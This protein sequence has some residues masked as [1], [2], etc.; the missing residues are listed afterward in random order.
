MVEERRS[1]GRRVPIGIAAVVLATGVLVGCGGSSSS[2]NA[3]KSTSNTVNVDAPKQTGKVDPNATLTVAYPADPATFDPRLPVNAYKKNVDFSIYDTLVVKDYHHPDKPLDI[4][5]SLATEWKV[6]DDGLTYSFTLRDGVKFSDGSAFDADD[7]V[8]TFRSIVDKSFKGF[9]EECNAASA[10]DNSNID[11]VAKTGP[12]AVDIKLKKPFGGFLEMLSSQSQFAILTA[13]EVEAGSKAINAKPIG[14]GY[15]TLKEY[16][17]N[18][19]VVLERND[20]HWRGPVAYKELIIR[21]MP[22]PVAR[23]NAIVAGE[24]D[25]ANDIAPAYITEWADNDAVRAVVRPRPRQYTCQMNYRGDGPTSKKEVR[26]AL[27][28]A[29]DRDAMNKAL[30]QGRGTP[31]SGW[32][33]AGNPAFDK[34]MPELAYDPAKA[35]QLLDAAGYGKG[36]KLK[37]EVATVAADEPK[38]LAIWQDELRKIGVT[39][40]IKTVD[41]ATWVTDWNKGLPPAPKGM[42]GMCLLSGSDVHWSLA[43][44]VGSYG[45]VKG[46]NY[47]AGGYTNPEAE[48]DFKQAADAKSVDDYYAA[49]SAANKVITD[50]FA[51]IMMVV[52]LN[53]YGVKRNV[54]WVPSQA[55]QSL[56]YNAKVFAK[57]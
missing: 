54:E 5:P 29:A 53:L 15:L 19:R 2:N 27:S 11:S 24:V 44:F 14:T 13:E 36:L 12:L 34:S 33:T 48:A 49:L 32:W 3:S 25:I 16:V 28:L 51:M 1:A 47:N 22:D 57:S 43:Q 31:S 9:C 50:D 8:A 6:S 21:P 4:V 56:W 37:M 45:I 10:R 40:D 18:Q 42:D 26:E 39:L 46:A 55:I 7:V 23:A 20:S 41:L 52:D 30:Y 17:P 38:L 35:K